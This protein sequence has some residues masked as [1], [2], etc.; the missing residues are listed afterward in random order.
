M[1]LL[2]RLDRHI[3]EFQTSLAPK[4]VEKL[5]S[6]AELKVLQCASSIEPKTSDL[7]NQILFIRRPDIE[8]RL[9]G[10]YSSVCD[11]SFLSRLTNVRRFSADCLM[12]A[13]GVEHLGDLENLEELSVGIYDLQNFDF[14]GLIPDGI[15]RLSLAATKSKKP[16][17]DLLARFD[18]LSRLYLE[19]QQQEIEV[20]SQLVTLEDI[21]LRSISTKNLDYLAGLPRLWSLGIKLGGIQNFSSVADK[22]SIKY[23]ELWQ[24]RGLSDLSFVSSM[25]G[26]QFLF[27]QSLRNVSKIPNLSKLSNLRRLYLENMKGIKDVSEIAHAPA[28]EEFI[29]VSARNIAPEKYRDLFKMPSLRSVRVGFGSPKKNQ[30]FQS[31]LASSGKD[32]HLPT[33]FVFR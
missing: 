27:L 15:R 1:T 7:L 12:K 18:S 31:L 19:G 22:Q 3:Q 32:Q 16:R 20:L 24:I 9:Y 26:L 28:L 6:D 30:E 4:D 33:G 11:L 17:L 23:L 29:H 5:A 2:R 10:F 14:L 25:T 21:T 13:V 8:F